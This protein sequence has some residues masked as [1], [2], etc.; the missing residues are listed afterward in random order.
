MSQKIAIIGSGISGLGAAWHLDQQS[1]DITLYEKNDYIGGHSNTVQVK[2]HPP[3]DTGF[4]V[5]NELTYPNLIALFDKIKARVAP[6]DMSYGISVN[7]G[8]NEYSSDN[9][10]GDTAKFFKPWYTQMLID[11]V[12]FYKT[13]PGFLKKPDPEVSL[14]QYLQKHHYSKSFIENHIFPMG[15]AIWSMSTEEMK[16]FPA[17]TFIR[18]FVNHGLFNLIKRPQWYTVYNGSREYVK[19]LTKNFTDKIKLDAPI[20]KIE[21]HDGQIIV[22]DTIYDHVILA[23]HSDQA[24]SI[25]KK[26]FPDQAALLSKIS[27]SKNKA[28][29][30]MDDALMPIDKKNWA[31]W[32]SMANTGKNVCLTYWMN[33]LQPHLP[34]NRNYFVTLNPDRAIDKKK[35]LKEIDYEHPC[36]N[37]TS[38]KAQSAIKTIQGHNNL[39]F[40]GA[41]CGYGFHEDGLVSGLKIAE[42]VSG[43]NRPWPV[44]E[45]K[46]SSAFNTL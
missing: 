42:T 12:R 29:L 23:T 30:H 19:N 25:I 35:I 1:F 27:Y 37:K 31:S 17:L 24:A 6:S 41:W 7:A 8:T 28:V 40:C 20:H 32:N 21:K 11:I 10:F 44:K 15:A 26:H 16:N 36:Y 14:E 4:I 46:S 45:E 39:W 5:F 22:N 34:E 9:I 18:F 13:A 2:G 43:I 38:L 3:I 33:R